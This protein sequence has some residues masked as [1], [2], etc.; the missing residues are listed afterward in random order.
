M[1]QLSQIIHAFLERFRIHFFLTKK[2]VYQNINKFLSYNYLP[3]I[4][5]YRNFRKFIFRN[6]N[7]YK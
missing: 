2:N 1:S 5:I 6:A 4:Y 7:I 3:G